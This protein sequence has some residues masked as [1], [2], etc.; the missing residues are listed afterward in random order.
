MIGLS[1]VSRLNSLIQHISCNYSISQITPNVDSDFTLK[2]REWDTN[3]CRFEFLSELDWIEGTSCVFD[4]TSLLSL[5]TTRRISRE[6]ES[7][8]DPKFITNKY[9]Y[10]TV[11]GT[12][13]NLIKKPKRFEPKRRGE[14]RN[15]VLQVPVTNG[16]WCLQFTGVR[17]GGTCW[18][19]K[20][21]RRVVPSRFGDIKNSTFSTVHGT[22]RQERNTI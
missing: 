8:S 6:G 21:G 11:D 22:R 13:S 9:F 5:G 15:E 18:L 12:L 2:D 20:L 10:L 7:V 1:F 17:G 14:R 16:V 3:H 4:R 19:R